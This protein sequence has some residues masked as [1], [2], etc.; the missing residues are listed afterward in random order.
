[1]GSDLLPVSGAGLVGTASAPVVDGVF[2]DVVAAFLRDGPVLEGAAGGEGPEERAFADAEVVE[3]C[4]AVPHGRDGVE[5]RVVVGG[6]VG[7]LA[8]GLL[9]GL[10]GPAVQG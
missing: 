7:V 5:E 6:D 4:E 2:G 1:M 8:L 10:G 9:V 3:G